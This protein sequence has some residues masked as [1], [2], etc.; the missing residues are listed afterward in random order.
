MRK[1]KIAEAII[2]LRPWP[3]LRCATTS[4]IV[5]EAGPARAGRVSLAARLEHDAMVLLSLEIR[6]AADTR[7]HKSALYPISPE[8]SEYSSTNEIC[9]V[10]RQWNMLGSCDEVDGPES[11]RAALVLCAHAVVPTSCQ[12]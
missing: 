8:C 2:N 10:E 12:A 11:G 7:M 6:R 9:D 4:R 1:L 3:D 5:G